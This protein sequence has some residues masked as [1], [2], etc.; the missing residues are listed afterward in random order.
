M[1]L[2]DEDEFIR[3][4][5]KYMWNSAFVAIQF[6]WSHHRS[7]GAKFEYFTETLFMQLDR[8]SYLWQNNSQIWSS[9][10]HNSQQ[11]IDSKYRLATS[12]PLLCLHCFATWKRWS[13]VTRTAPEGKFSPA[14][15][16]CY[17]NIWPQ[18]CDKLLT[19]CITRIIIH[20]IGNDLN[21]S[22]LPISSSESSSETYEKNISWFSK[23][24]FTY[25]D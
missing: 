12:R 16:V 24:T 2:Y 6:G 5:S 19:P 1:F 11:R 4:A 21:F 15:A 25:C 10:L 22:C 3:R 7:Q 17:R 23:G 13:R 8:I 20:G 9:L 18:L 14:Q